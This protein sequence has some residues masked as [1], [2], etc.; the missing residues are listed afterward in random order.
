MIRAIK[1]FFNPKLKCERIG[2]N[3]AEIEK[4][5]RKEGGGFRAVATDYKCKVKRCKRC[6]KESEPYDLKEYDSYT[7]VTMPSSMWDEI[8]EKG[9]LVLR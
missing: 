6:H 2:H 9:Y 4:K 5:I 3:E 1:E 8:K 7:S